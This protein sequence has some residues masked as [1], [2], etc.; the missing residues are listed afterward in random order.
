MNFTKRTLSVV[1]YAHEL[2]SLSTL[3]DWGSV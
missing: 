3:R 1:G 2:L